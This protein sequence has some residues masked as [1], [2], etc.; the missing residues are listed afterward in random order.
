M[1]LV[2][3][4]IEICIVQGSVNIYNLST[5]LLRKLEGEKLKN[6]VGNRVFRI[7]HTIIILKSFGS[8]GKF[9]P[10]TIAMKIIITQWHNQVLTPV[11]AST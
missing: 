9:G 2:H 11:G 7:Q 10:V 4:H 1:Q 5:I 8:R 6:Q 3:V